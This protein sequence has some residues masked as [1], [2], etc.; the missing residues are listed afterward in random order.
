MNKYICSKCKKI[1]NPD[2]QEIKRRGLRKYI[3]CPFC[4]CRYELLTFSNQYMR[5]ENGQLI[6]RYKKR[7]MSK[8]QRRKLKKTSLKQHES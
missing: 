4:N 8:K 7:R 3:Y 6:N 5:L 2:T 1:F